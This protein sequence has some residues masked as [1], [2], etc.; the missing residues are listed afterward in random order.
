MVRRGPGARHNKNGRGRSGRGQLG[1]EVYSFQPTVHSLGSVAGD[2]RG[3]WQENRFH[4]GAG[5]FVSLI[6][7]P[8]GLFS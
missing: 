1:G 6:L 4:F 7:P 8:P 3:V 5:M 2:A